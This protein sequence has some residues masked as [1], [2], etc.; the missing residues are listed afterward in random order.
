MGLFNEEQ[1][2]NKKATCF[3]RRSDDDESQR[4]FL[5]L[6]PQAG[7]APATLGLTAATP[8]IDRVTRS[9]T[10]MMK[11]SQLRAMSD[12]ASTS[13]DHRNVR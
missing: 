7:F 12:P 8:K 3:V 4:N 1:K 9:V 5:G 11:I 13:V 2:G 6:A 10:K